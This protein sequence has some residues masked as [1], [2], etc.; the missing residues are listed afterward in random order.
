[1]GS[2]K[3]SFRYNKASYNIFEFLEPA[4]TARKRTT[5]VSHDGFI[6][7]GSPLEEPTEWLDP[8][9]EEQSSNRESGKL[10]IRFFSNYFQVE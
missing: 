8:Q 7:C 3:G 9:D 1:M 2:R 5:F 4:L 6:V 10:S